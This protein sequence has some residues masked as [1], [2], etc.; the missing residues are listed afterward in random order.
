MQWCEAQ[1]TFPCAP[2]RSTATWRILWYDLETIAILRTG[3]T[4]EKQRCVRQLSAHFIVSFYIIVTLFTVRPNCNCFS[5]QIDSD[6]DIHNKSVSY[7][8][9]TTV[10]LSVRL[11]WH[12]H[13]SSSSIIP[14][15]ST[16]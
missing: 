1:Q 16:E 2:L 9:P 15:H 6:D 10:I 5:E 8:L 14:R 4:N 11:L 3:S 12:L 13:L 7:C